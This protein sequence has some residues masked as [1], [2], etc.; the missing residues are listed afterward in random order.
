M[1][2]ELSNP[3]RKD[4]PP[5]RRPM[6]V[7]SREWARLYVMGGVFVAVV[8]TMAYMKGVISAPPPKPD[9]RRAGQADPGVKA[10]PATDPN[11]VKKE[12]TPAPLPQDG[13]TSFREYAAPFKDGLE[14]PE[15]ETPEFI[16]LLNVFLNSVTRESLSKLVT[17]GLNANRVFLEPEKHRGA[18]LKVYGRLIQV[19]TERVLATTP[20]NVEFV[21]VGILQEEA[22]GTRTVYFFMPEIPKDEKGQPLRFK[23]HRRQGIEFLE[24]FVEIEGVFLR[25]YLYPTHGQDSK[26]NDIYAQAAVMFVKTLRLAK[27]PVIADPRASFGIL[28]VVLLVLVV[29]II[30]LA[31]VMA[32]KYSSGSLRLKLHAMKVEKEKASQASPKAEAAVPAADAPVKSEGSS[33]DP[34]PPAP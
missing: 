31:G 33:A 34:G 24:D 23:S 30:I 6:P 4:A 20:N 14:K 21:Y 1:D 15:K 29:G 25:N 8:G 13:V 11:P 18:V 32:R 12:V 7:S 28:V 27:A 22:P 10:A 19:F 5:P 16:N 17:P 3:F 26:G 9:A 2:P